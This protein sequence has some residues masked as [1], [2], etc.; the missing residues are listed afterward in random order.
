MLLS[1]LLTSTLGTGGLICKYSSTLV[2]TVGHF[3]DL[4]IKSILA[5][6]HGIFL[7]IPSTQKSESGLKLQVRLCPQNLKKAS[8]V[9]C[10]LEMH[11]ALPFDSQ[12]SS[13]RKRRRDKKSDFV[14]LMYVYVTSLLSGPPC[15]NSF[16]DYPLFP[17]VGFQ[18]FLLIRF[19]VYL[20]VCVC[21]FLY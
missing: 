2:H 14:I 3:L 12:I 18:I 15:Q 21:S 16:S 11:M 4:I 9:N 20:Y 8:I 1:V 7:K 17:I 10:L 6:C 5:Q 13:K 19:D